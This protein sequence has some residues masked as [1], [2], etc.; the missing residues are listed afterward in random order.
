VV[1]HRVVYAVAIVA[2]SLVTALAINA[3]KRL[4]ERT[5]R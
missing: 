3:L 5:D 2:G 1:D 4:T